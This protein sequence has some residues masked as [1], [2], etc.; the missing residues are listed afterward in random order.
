MTKEQLV[1]K[2]QDFVKQ[3]PDEITLDND[4]V[5]WIGNTN[6]ELCPIE[7]ICFSTEGNYYFGAVDSAI[8]DLGMTQEDAE[9]IIGAADY[10]LSYL[11]EYGYKGKHELRKQLLPANILE[12]DPTSLLE[13]EVSNG[14]HDE[15]EVS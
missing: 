4:L 3:H 10:P 7:A 2:W 8:E 9:D 13:K 1:E 14:S 11:D 5:R 12:V 6:G 15:T